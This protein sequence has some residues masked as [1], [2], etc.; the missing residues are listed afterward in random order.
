MI[1]AD[2]ALRFIVVGALFSLVTLVGTAIR[3]LPLSTAMLYVCAGAL[4]GPHA[5]G[6]LDARLPRDAWWLEQVTQ[7]AVLVSL[8]ST[9]L[10]LRA[11]WRAARWR[12]VGLLG[13]GVTALTALTVAAAGVWLLGC[14]WGAALLLGGVLAPTDP[15]LA[16]DVQLEHPHDRSPLRFALTGEA[17]LN[18]GTA[19]PFVLLGLGLLV[20]P[21]QV[22][23][24]DWILRDVVWATSSALLIGWGLATFQ[25]RL[26]L[27]LRR[28]YGQAVGLDHFLAIGLIALSYGLATSAHGYGFLA[29]FAAGLSLRR[30]ELEEVGENPP[31][32]L[33]QVAAVPSER[34]QV[35]TDDR[36]APVYLTQTTLRFTELVEQIGEA[37]VM[38]LVGAMLP[39]SVG[40]GRTLIFLLLLIVA[41]RPAAV[42]SMLAWTEATPRE[43]GLIGWFGI[44]GVASI[45]YVAYA[46]MH[47]APDAVIAPIAHLTLAVVAASVMLHGLS[48]TPLMRRYNTQQ[49]TAEEEA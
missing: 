48:V 7:I 18:D 14:S 10:H 5:L 15:V 31:E 1:H 25:G 4:L 21:D 32:E 43:R 9:G 16:R 42:W 22:S 13:V 12:W 37:F 24:G 2:E 11:P 19:F 49:T 46:A 20:S 23:L 39:W 17:G 41:I 40:S 29:V 28:R 38:T 33:T 35:A 45:Y 8:F 47:G 30:V 34:T 44:R 6:L 36:T 27:H 3:R 26:V